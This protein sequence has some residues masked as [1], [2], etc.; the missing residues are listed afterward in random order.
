MIDEK[1]RGLDNLL[2][3]QLGPL[4]KASG[5]SFAGIFG[6]P[7]YKRAERE[8]VDFARHWLERINLI[9][10][11]DTDAGSLPY[12]DQR[13]LESARAMCTRPALLCLDEPAAGLNPR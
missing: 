7:S 3:S 12:G 8:A 6:L 13:R 4:M 10:R 9:D 2:V 1:I 11:A 5:F